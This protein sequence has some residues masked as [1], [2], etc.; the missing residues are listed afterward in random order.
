MSNET[1]IAKIIKL[2]AVAN[3]AGATEAERETARSMVDKLMNQH[4]ID[5]LENAE[6]D[7]I[8]K[9]SYRYAKGKG[10]KPM[11][12]WLE[13]IIQGIIG[14]YGAAAALNHSENEVIFYASP[15][16]MKAIRPIVEGFIS[17]VGPEWRAYAKRTGKKTGTYRNNFRTG[18]A[19][20]VRQALQEM[21]ERADKMRSNG[22]AIVVIDDHAE[23]AANA[24]R[25]AGIVKT[26]KSRDRLKPGLDMKAGYDAHRSKMSDPA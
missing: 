9:W 10:G 13:Q 2:N 17:D 1:I 26:R 6:L 19:L 11:P 24:M 4:N 18:W 12:V 7:N 14:A 22:A 5:T 3:D 23:K 20:S 21:K 25:E 15:K 8:E 16:I